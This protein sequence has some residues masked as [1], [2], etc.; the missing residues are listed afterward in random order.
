MNKEKTDLIFDL[1]EPTYSLTGEWLDYSQYGFDHD[2]VADLILL[3]VD[4]NL[5]FADDDS[6][7]VPAHAWRILGQLASDDAVLPLI[8]LF[9][10]LVEQDD[11][12]GLTDLPHVMG[13]IGPAAIAPLASFMNDDK[14][15]EFARIAAMESLSDIVK[16]HTESRKD[17]LSVYQT[18]L[19]YPEPE[20]PTM[21]G[22]L[23][24]CVLDIEG[25]ELI[26]DLR[27]VFEHGYVDL[28][29]VGD[30][31]DVEI[32]L[33]LRDERETPKPSFKGMH[34][35]SRDS[36]EGMTP[37]Q[38]MAMALDEE[39]EQPKDKEDVVGWLNYYLLLYGNDDS[40]I[41][42]SELDGF[43]ASLAC[44]PKT[45][46]PSTWIPAIWGGEAL[47]P[48]WESMKDAQDFNTFI[49]TIYNHVI[50]TLDNNEYEALFWLNDVDDKQYKI[51]D[52]W[53]NGFLRGV[54]LWGAMPSSDV[55]VVENSLQPMRLFA[56]ERGFEKLEAMS[57]DE[58][59]IQQDL[60]E[61]KVQEL[62]AYFLEQRKKSMAPIVR[63]EDK[64]RRN[65]P[66]PCGSGQ[67]Y[68]KCC[69]H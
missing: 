9:S 45:V 14:Q 53:C 11:T 29:V 35:M 27:T 62:F 50:T 54:N 6:M 12:M 38:V 44:S 30:I 1:D 51:V 41:D 69:L 67:K 18:Y 31:E 42:T 43:C 52:E 17:V 58:V 65:D 48:E 56:T 33:K 28:S 55:S 37:D 3:A 68:K 23:I 61:P 34:G 21:N 32:A 5:H 26:E 7:W 59:E 20:L 47:M 49:F 19:K 24:S 57:S 66:C 15:D 64:I 13:L 16:Q 46:M 4:E 63:N 60:I 2:D 40:I 8:G 25:K 36:I 39:L 10:L 22:L